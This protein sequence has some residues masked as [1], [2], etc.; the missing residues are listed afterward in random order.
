[1]TYISVR[2]GT[3]FLGGEGEGWVIWVFFPKTVLA[4]PCTLIKKLLTPHL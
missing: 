4:L 1:M 3:F 2:E